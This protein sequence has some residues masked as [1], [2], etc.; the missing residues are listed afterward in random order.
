M[1]SSDKRLLWILLAG[2][3]AV[4]AI[5]LANFALQ[6][7]RTTRLSY[8]ELLKVVGEGQVERIEL[9][10]REVDAQL[11]GGVHAKSFLPSVDAFLPVLV[12]SGIDVVARQEEEHFSLQQ[13]VIGLLPVFVLV[14]VMLVL[15]FRPGGRGR[16]ANWL[17]KSK[18]RRLDAQ[19]STVSFADVAGAG[20]AKQS[21][22]EIV[23]FLRA[24]ERY[25]ALGGYIPKGVLMVGPP[26]S[27]KTLLAKAVAGEAGVPFFA[28]SGS[29]F[30][31]MFVG[32][33]ASRVRSMFEAAKQLA[34]S[35]VFIDEIDAVGRNRGHAASAHGNDER[36]QTL[37]QLLVEMDGIGGD[38]G[39]IV[40]AA[41]N[42]PDV[43]DPA[44]VRSGRFDREI[45]VDHPGRQARRQMFEL[46]LSRLTLDEGVDVEALAA[47]TPGLSGADIANLVNES[48]LSAVRAGRTKVSPEDLQ[49]ARDRLSAGGEFHHSL[50][51]SGERQRAA[52]RAAASALVATQFPGAHPIERVSLIPRGRSGSNLL[53]ITPE[54]GA[55]TLLEMRAK[56]AILAAGRAAETIVFGTDEVSIATSPGLAEATEIARDMVARWAMTDDLGGV[57]LKGEAD[58]FLGPTAISTDMLAD[59]DIRR[60]SVATAKLVGDA[61]ATASACLQNNRDV[62]D[63]LSDAIAE[64]EALNGSEVAAI[65]AGTVLPMRHQA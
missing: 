47:A 50:A 40:I 46:H 17:G 23:D 4:V 65:V 53:Q 5:A 7:E 51:T 10:G 27:G 3:L 59:E 57:A 15:I 12:G 24:P 34:P 60:I 56:L 37:N 54:S 19:S 43:L 38:Q 63:A 48:V 32:V 39:V 9:T 55:S 13:T 25:L 52:Y 1:D 31:E 20:E 18:A 16:E 58:G 61:L 62:L 26:G 29:D 28:I 33:G 8:S 35:I 64:R 11:T 44:L 36:E 22:A 6:P 49:G 30:V 42:R 45:L 2:I 41:T 21:L 14:A